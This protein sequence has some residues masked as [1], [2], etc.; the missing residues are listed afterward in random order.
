MITKKNAFKQKQSETDKL[1]QSA[2]GYSDR[3]NPD[4]ARAPEVAANEE[5]VLGL[6]LV[7]PEFRSLVVKD[8]MLSSEDFIT[9]LNRRIFEYLWELNDNPEMDEINSKFNPDEVGRITKI[10]VNRMKFPANGNEIL[11]E[12][13]NMLKKNVQKKSAENIHTFD[14]LNNL[15]NLKRNN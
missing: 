1:I 9:D 12:A 14:E 5:N 15:L 3:V 13:V 6:M 11:Y 10:K 8:R 7:Y 4:F 2:Y